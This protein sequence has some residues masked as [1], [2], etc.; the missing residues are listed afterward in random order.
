MLKPAQA[1]FRVIQGGRDAHEWTAAEIRSVFFPTV[2]TLPF[3]KLKKDDEP[4]WRPERYW[5]VEP[6]GRWLA[7]RKLGASYARDLLAAMRADG[8]RSSVLAHVLQDLIRDCRERDKEE[9][10][11]VIGFLHELARILMREPAESTL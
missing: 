5:C 11:L 7:Q 4:S 3:V 8:C 9:G 2:K 10:P 1:S 6:Q